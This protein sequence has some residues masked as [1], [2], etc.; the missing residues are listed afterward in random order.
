MEEKKSRDA[1]TDVPFTKKLFTKNTC[2]LFHFE[3]SVRVFYCVMASQGSKRSK[4]RHSRDRMR[5]DLL[6]WFSFRT[7]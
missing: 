3:V 6:H 7:V 2:A 1:T 4:R 5:C